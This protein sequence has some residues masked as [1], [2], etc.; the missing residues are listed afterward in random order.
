MSCWLLLSIDKR[1]V[2]C[3]LPDGLIFGHAQCD[4]GIHLPPLRGGF[5]LPDA[6]HDDRLPGWNV[7]DDSQ[8]EFIDNLHRLH[9]R[10][11]FVWHRRVVAFDL[12]RVSDRIL[13]S[14]CDIADR[15]SNGLIQSTGESIK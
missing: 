6:F 13:L 15:L 12:F 10:I 7:F 5:L 2:T 4:F 8:C 3:V 9:A 1:N 14:E 11:Y